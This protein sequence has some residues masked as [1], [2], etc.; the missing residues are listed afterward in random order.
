MPDFEATSPQAYR[1]KN[2]Y[3]PPP[4]EYKPPSMLVEHRGLAI[5]F[6]AIIVG[7]ALYCWKAPHRRQRTAEPPA[8]ASAAAPEFNRAAPIYVEPVPEKDNQ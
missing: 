6:V 2:P 8:P 3:T 4:R 5:L 1:E 7:F